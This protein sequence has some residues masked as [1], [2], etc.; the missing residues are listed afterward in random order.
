[1]QRSTTSDSVVE[2]NAE[3]VCL[4]TVPLTPRSLSMPLVAGNVDVVLRP[5]VDRLQRVADELERN[6]DAD[7]QR[8][9]EKLERIEHQL[10]R[11][12]QQCERRLR[13]YVVK[14]PQVALH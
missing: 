11:Q 13:P 3:D 4:S 8:V 10:D 2:I 1:M 7:L 9:E 14:E 12:F 5:N 6:I